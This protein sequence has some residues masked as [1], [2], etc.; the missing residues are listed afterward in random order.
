M[1]KS[2][3]EYLP[4][5]FMPRLSATK[6][7]DVSDTDWTKSWRKSTCEIQNPRVDIEPFLPLLREVLQVQSAH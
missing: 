7:S 1:V 6:L 2:V 5:D 3:R 4:E